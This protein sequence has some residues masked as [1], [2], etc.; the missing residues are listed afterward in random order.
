[1]ANGTKRSRHFIIK[2]FAETQAYRSPQQGGGRAVVPRRDRPR[3]AGALQLQVEA[4]RRRADAARDAQQAAATDE[5][6]LPVE[7]EGFPGI[8]LA[9]ESLARERSGIE[10]LNV[11]RAGDLTR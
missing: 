9:F 5:V 4:V 10:L 8:E 3:H 7:F 2:G 6:G 1:M 11:R